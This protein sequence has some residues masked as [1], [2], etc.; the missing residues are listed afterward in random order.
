MEKVHKLKLFI[1]ANKIA[2][3]NS[4]EFMMNTYEQNNFY[5]Y[6]FL[7]YSTDIPS[8]VIHAIENWLQ[9]YS[10]GCEDLKKITDDRYEIIEKTMLL[11]EK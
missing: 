4:F 1:H 5:L 8:E 10:K 6:S 3:D 11:E 9:G 2:F 7:K